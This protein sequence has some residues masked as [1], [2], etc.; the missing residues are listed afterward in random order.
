ML[1]MSMFLPFLPLYVR[2]LGVTDL[3][4]VE[5]VSGLLFAAPFFAATVATPVWG[6]LG[7]RHGRKLMV[8]RASFGLAAAT[9]LMGF[10]RTIPQLLV[11][12]VAQGAVSGFI[13][14]ALALMASS[15]PRERMG[16]ALG[17]LQTAIP[18]GTILGPLL[19]GTLADLIG[20][21][22]I[23]FVTA[24]SNF[25][26][27]LLVIRLVREPT[28][29]SRTAGLGRVLENYRAVFGNPQFRLLFLVL[30]GSQFAL[31][32]LTPIM[33]LYVESVGAS[34]ALLATTTGVIFAVTGVASAVAAPRWGRASDRRGYRRTL[35]RA[36]LGTGLFAA[37]QGL[38]ATPWQ[39]FLLR[40]PYG[41][42][43]GGVVP[44]AQAMI[45]L[46]APE[47]RRAGIMGVTSTAL[48]LGN[49][50][51]PL[52]GGALAGHFGLRSVFFLSAGVLVLLLL[53]VHPRI[54][55]PEGAIPGQP[56]G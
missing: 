36:L 4:R 21:R 48:M 6:F 38:A 33:A 14:A 18:T 19:G 32:S 15:A 16:Y 29:G 22:Q 52:V 35:G 9:L 23:F 41:A 24:A 7:D 26:G 42:F 39:L 53:A 3:A 56:A 45:G 44:S 31:M 25:V 49:L 55:E 11:L 10:A 5:A 17:T 46:R 37:P 30:L 13:A 34:G 2:E 51:G 54:R 43:L 40:I 1:G 8:V 28:G 47:E 20:Y 27:G 12:R 50:T